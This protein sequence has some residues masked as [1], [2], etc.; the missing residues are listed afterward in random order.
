M[1]KHLIA[2]GG[3]GQHVALAYMDLAALVY[4]FRDVP[5]IALY[6]LDKDET[7]S[8]GKSAW[9]EAIDQG[10]RLREAQP[11]WTDFRN[12]RIP[13]CRELPNKTEVRDAVSKVYG[14]LLFTEEQL[15]VE[16]GTG[17]WGH[18]P[19]GAVFFGEMLRRESGQLGAA[20][21]QIVADQDGNKRVVVAG[22]LVGGT[23]AGCLPQLVKHL[24][25]AASD[26][27]GGS[28]IMALALLQWFWLRAPTD[29]QRA[30]DADLR[31]AQMK[32]R[33]PSALLYASTELASDA[34]TV[35]IGHP[36]P[37]AAP[38]RPWSGDTQ[39]APHE[40]LTIP[41]YAAAL[42]SD[43]LSSSTAR[44]RG[45]F[46]LACPPFDAGSVH[47][48]RGLWLFAGDERGESQLQLGNLVRQNY[49]LCRRL[50]WVLKYLEAPPVA[51][52]ALRQGLLRARDIDERWRRLQRGE[53]D[54]LLKAARSML[55]AKWAAL[56]RLL[57]SEKGL[58]EFDIPRGE[59][60]WRGHFER[61]PPERG[62]NDIHDWTKIAPGSDGRAAVLTLR[63]LT[64]SLVANLEKPPLQRLE[65]SS[66]RCLPPTTARR[67]VV[68]PGAQHPGSLDICRVD[69]VLARE[70]VRAEALPTAS[71]VEF[72]LDQLF[73]GGLELEGS[74]AK[75]AQEWLHRWHLLLIGLAGGDLRLQPTAP[76]D[77]DGDVR[78]FSEQ[79]QYRIVDSTGSSCYGMTSTRT[80]LV[81]AMTAKWEE[82]ANR[83]R[84]HGPTD[85]PVRVVAGWLDLLTLL[86][87]RTGQTPTPGWFTFH[88]NHRD[89]LNY[90]LGSKEDG[91]E[92]LPPNPHFG[93]LGKTPVEVG[94]QARDTRRLLLPVSRPSVQSPTRRDLEAVLGAFGIQLQTTPLGQIPDPANQLQDLNDERKCPTYVPFGLPPR[95][96]EVGEVSRKVVWRQERPELAGAIERGFFIPPGDGVADTAH[97]IRIPGVHTIEVL[98][99]EDVLLEEIEPIGDERDATNDHAHL[100]DLY[101]TYPV[102][103]RY[104]GL[105]DLEA[106]AS[107]HPAGAVECQYTFNLR[108][109]PTPVSHSARVGNKR[110]ATLMLWPDFRPQPVTLDGPL[111]GVLQE[112]ETDR[113]FKAYFA[114]FDS[115]RGGG[116]A[117][118]LGHGSP[119]SSHLDWAVQIDNRESAQPLY[120]I[121]GLD[122]AGGTPRLMAVVQDDVRGN[123]DP[124]NKGGGLFSCA[125]DASV[126]NVAAEQWGLD[127]G[128][129]SS[130]VAISP[131]GGVTAPIPAME[132]GVLS[133][134]GLLDATQVFAKNAPKTLETCSW[135]PTWD[136]FSPRQNADTCE[137]I[138]SQLLIT[139]RAEFFKGLANA[140]GAPYGKA[141]VLDHG[142]ALDSRLMRQESIVQDLKWMDV[143][144]TQR[145]DAEQ[146]A[147]RRA[148]LLHLLELCFTLRARFAGGGVQRG[149]PVRVTVVFT[150]PLRMRV[151]GDQAAKDFTEDA[152]RVCTLLGALLG[153]EFTAAFMWESHAG[154]PAVRTEHEIHA[155]ADLGGGTLDLWG[156]IGPG[157][158]AEFADSYRFG[159]HDLLRQ[160]SEAEAR[161]LDRD[162]L[163]TDMRRLFQLAPG[164]ALVGVCGKPACARLQKEFFLVA[165]EAVARWIAAIVNE[166]RSHH[167]MKA[168]E[169]RLS[170]LGLG[171][172]LNS[173]IAEGHENVFRDSIGE[174]VN[175][176]LAQKG[177]GEEVRVVLVGPCARG[178][179]RKTC[180]ARRAAGGEGN[181]RDA[182]MA[183][184]THSFLGLDIFASGEHRWWEVSP[185]KLGD[186]KGEVHF[187]K[188]NG[189]AQPSPDIGETVRSMA[190]D[191]IQQ[192]MKS[193]VAGDARGAVY[194]GQM[195]LSLVIESLRGETGGSPSEEPGSGGGDGQPG[196]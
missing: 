35:L 18:A 6:I 51:R 4:G 58:L 116:R 163:N 149:L 139:D 43:Y 174:R 12:N 146:R 30:K 61:H 157:Q 132:A 62:V 195:P 127:F 150:L 55:D 90:E 159:G 177:S 64:A 69:Q 189:E 161:S 79:P 26:G 175:Q 170:L 166:A 108:G 194:S 2:V 165:R 114:L 32:S 59:G 1:A 44:D 181:S 134:S 103:C 83:I 162:Q 140:D 95:L 28:Q 5:S 158:G 94:W 135:F 47:L 92:T 53:Q 125:P 126:K 39:Q 148:Y 70:H 85:A 96:N 113:A 124:L 142:H 89:L 123:P 187:N 15:R 191:Q 100:D 111:V 20:L 37:A 56:G 196:K 164:R 78:L 188:T 68:A 107:M 105:V 178:H 50:A 160:W 14:S 117:W 81:P 118:F 8:E 153:R 183:Q 121:A 130:V 76:N 138:P 22:S 99:K 104:A 10:Q 154:A 190:L 33:V 180:L 109:I 46:A 49:E 120:R 179:A 40:D 77:D 131:G 93:F 156:A 193:A 67:Q 24:A 38:N 128:S 31:N 65:M 42:A 171:W 167:G 88:R 115:T 172:S 16:F 25:E 45:I 147:L 182:L 17:Y 41:Y 80:L 110:Q 141:F 29:P 106:P 112:T 184:E 13:P 72:Y 101:P 137:L 84:R 185:V 87:R 192:R 19:V 152:Q 86:W 151:P 71:A 119:S 97:E 176:L 155:V 23:G 3:S 7:K 9:Q 98:D 173:L 145:S 52:Y 129:S 66:A 186:Y 169:V 75:T 143:A 133:F 27:P 36:S 57:L 11:D 122:V 74:S 136:G 168:E 82:L 48:D 73:S 63:S 91:R 21:N 102:K 34:C 54:V 60:T 144:P